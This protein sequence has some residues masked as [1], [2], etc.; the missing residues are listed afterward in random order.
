MEIA[1]VTYL[2]ALSAPGL[3]DHSIAIA[4]THKLQREQQLDSMSL[5][6][7]QSLTNAQAANLDDR[8]RL[9]LQ[10]LDLQQRM[11]QQQL[12]QQQLRQSS[13]AN[14][15]L[16][17]QPPSSRIAQSQLEQRQFGQERRQQLQLFEVQRQ[18]QLQQFQWER[19]QQSLIKPLAPRLFTLR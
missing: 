3:C 10:Q 15:L 7:G 8:Q 9:Q 19:Q 4:D 5:S 6:I 11:Q 16:R 2:L 18:R 17:S 13:R 1:C 14:E 12:E